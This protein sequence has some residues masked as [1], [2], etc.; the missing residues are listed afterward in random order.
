MVTKLQFMNKYL[1]TILVFCF[2]ESCILAQD[3]LCT[4]CICL[5]EKAEKAQAMKDYQTAIMR[6]NAVSLC[7]ETYKPRANKRILNIYQEYILELIAHE[8]HLIYDNI[9]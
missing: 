6:Y 9:Y 7:D 4:Q 2:S 1:I 3:T 5:W 8:L